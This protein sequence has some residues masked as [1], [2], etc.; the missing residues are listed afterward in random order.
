[1]TLKSS[2]SVIHVNVD[3]KSQSKKRLSF[4][5]V[6][7]SL[8]VRV[9]KMTIAWT[10]IMKLNTGCSSPQSKF[11][12]L[13][14]GADERAYGYVTTKISQMHETENLQETHS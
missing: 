11:T 8:K 13:S 5:V 14:C 2:F 12:W 6:F 4:V 7:F 1:M 3:M 9:A 10:S